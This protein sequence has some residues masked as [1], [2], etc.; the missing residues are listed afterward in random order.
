MASQYFNTSN[1]QNN[2][3]S[4]Q[5]WKQ[6]LKETQ[7]LRQNY[8]NLIAEMK[9]MREE[10]IRATWGNKFRHKLARLLLR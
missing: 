6:L 5:Q 3:S 8:E 2:Y 1:R 7:G 9:L 10:V 4:A